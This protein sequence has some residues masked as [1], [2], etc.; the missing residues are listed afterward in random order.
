MSD[1][2]GKYADSTLQ[3]YDVL[4]QT[5]YEPYNDEYRVGNTAQ[6]PDGATMQFEIWSKDGKKKGTR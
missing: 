3:V 1:A 4:H 6:T 5:G 2:D